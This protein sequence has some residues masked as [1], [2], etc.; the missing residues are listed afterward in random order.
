MGMLIGVALVAGATVIISISSSSVE[1]RL[2]EKTSIVSPDGTDLAEVIRPTIPDQLPA[3]KKRT[4]EEPVYS[5]GPRIHVVVSGETLTGISKEYYG[6]IDGKQA[7]INANKDI[8]SN[9]D[10]LRAGTR[11]VIP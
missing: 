1:S 9:A 3:L 8:I 6:T 7:I 10:T 5:V 11:L 4:N 2:V